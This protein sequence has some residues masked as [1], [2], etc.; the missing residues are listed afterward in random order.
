VHGQK[1]DYS[2]SDYHGSALKVKIICPKHGVFEQ[3]PNSHTRGAGCPQCSKTARKTTEQFIYDARLVHGEKYDYSLVD[4]KNTDSK[5]KI[6]CPKHGVFEQAATGHLQGNGCPKCAQTFKR[7]KVKFDI[8]LFVDRARLVHGEKYDYSLVDYKNTDSKVKIICPKHG[9]FEQVTKDHLKGHGCNKCANIMRSLK[10]KG[11]SPGMLGVDRKKKATL[12]LLEFK[13]NYADFWK[14][15]IT[16]QPLNRRFKADYK[17]INRRYEWNLNGFTAWKIEQELLN[18]F[19]P[20]QMRLLLP[21][22]TTSGDTE[23]FS[24]S[25]P[26]KKVIN[27]IT[28]L[29]K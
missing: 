20:Y 3:T 29:T 10:K 5:V 8:R 13:T 25:L 21:L 28:Q 19:K 6:I 22:L 23:C 14:I 1:Y 24:A 9:V 4:Y 15:G 7:R 12:Y 11:V 2:L 26:V 17:Y 18:K 16:T 27:T